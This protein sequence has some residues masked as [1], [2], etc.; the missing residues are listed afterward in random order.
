MSSLNIIQSFPASEKNQHDKEVK[1][2]PMPSSF[3]F[4]TFSDINSMRNASAKSQIRKH[5]MKD[6]GAARRRPRQRRRG[7]IKVPLEFIPEALAPHP[8]SSSIDYGGVDPFLQYPVELDRDG[9]RLVANSASVYAGCDWL[10]LGRIADI[11][12][13]FGSAQK[14][15]REDWFTVALMSGM[16]QCPLRTLSI[17]KVRRLTIALRQRQRSSKHLPILHSSSRLSM[18]LANTIDLLCSIINL[19]YRLSEANSHN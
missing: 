10:E 3:A 2:I 5:A 17:A 1:R 6:I 12:T 8:A 13:M 18:C 7:Y 11:D 9:R 15:L 14:A 16:L 19:H 4:V